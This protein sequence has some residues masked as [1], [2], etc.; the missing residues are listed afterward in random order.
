[1]LQFLEFSERDSLADAEIKLWRKNSEK[2]L[3]LL[4]LKSLW[5]CCE[6]GWK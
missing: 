3:V 4:L 5:S 1:M 2:K 6:V